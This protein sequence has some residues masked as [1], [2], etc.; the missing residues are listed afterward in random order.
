[1]LAVLVFYIL[2][3]RFPDHHNYMAAGIVSFGVG[4][5]SEAAQIPGPRDAQF[6][7]L[8]VDGLGVFGALG[9]LSAFDEDVR[10][11]LSGWRK[12]ALPVLASLCLLIACAPTIWLSYAFTRQYLA[13]PELLTFEQGWERPTFGQTSQVRPTIVAA[14]KGWPAAGKWVGRSTEAGRRGTLVYL[15][16]WHDW[17]GYSKLSFIVAT[18]S[19]ETTIRI[20]VRDMAQ[21]DEYHGIAYDR[22]V[23]VAEEPRRVSVTIDEILSVVDVRPIDISRVESVVIGTTEPGKGIEVLLDDFRLE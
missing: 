17:T 12:P 5:L 15:H 20:S 4:V 9:V 21:D 7:D 23:N 18:T 6:S 1:M 14:P 11:K 8:V 2:Q 16:P 10:R 19:G 13:F 22:I 3:L